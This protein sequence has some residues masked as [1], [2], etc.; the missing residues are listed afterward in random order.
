MQSASTTGSRHSFKVPTR[1]LLPTS[2]T[3]NLS[4]VWVAWYKSYEHLRNIQIINHRVKLDIM[5]I[6]P[7]QVIKSVSLNLMFGNDRHNTRFFFVVIKYAPKLLVN[8]LPIKLKAKRKKG[9]KICHCVPM[10]MEILWL[11]IFFLKS[12]FFISNEQGK[13]YREK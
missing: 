9:K 12:S 8:F 7:N 6:T 2:F 4:I 11:T 1:N 3:C 10:R 5:T 13:S